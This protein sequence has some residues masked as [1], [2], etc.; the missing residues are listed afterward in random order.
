MS[1]RTMAAVWDKS[2]HAGT[3]LLMLLAIADFADDNGNAYPAVATLAM[4]CRM[5]PRN[6]N[7]I[8]T[9]L[10]ASGELEV[11]LNE[12]PKGCNRYRIRLDGVGL[13]PASP[14]K[15]ASPL[16]CTSPSEGGF[17]LNP[18][19]L[20]PEAGFSKP[21]KPASDEPSLNHQEP[22]GTSLA[23]PRRLPS[24]PF[25]AIVAAY[26]EALPDLPRV[27]VVDAKGRRKKLS[28]FWTFVFTS[29]RTD[30]TI[31]ATNADEA[32]VWIRGF[33]QRASRNDFIMGRTARGAGHEAWE[34]GLDY[35]VSEN[36]RI[37][38]IEKTRDA[39]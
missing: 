13:K 27:K 10:K 9:Q 5:T 26:H 19:S 12:G 16:K 30:G 25:E 17:T 36:G 7:H 37:Q 31:R 22:S 21:L 23:R 33:F 3:E 6:V 20:T 15:A 8:L 34:A 1:V 29:K 4:K 38:V 39:G 24:C 2:A 35:L 11:R 18:A 14:L 32:M 28:D